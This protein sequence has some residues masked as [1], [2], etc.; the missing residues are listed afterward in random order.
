MEGVTFRRIR[1]R[2]VPIKNSERKELR[3]GGAAIA[4]GAGVSALAGAAYRAINFTAT[5]LASRGTRINESMKIDPSPQLSMF[6][7]ARNEH[8]QAIASKAL[9]NAD[10]IGRFAKPTRLI[11]LAIGSSAIAYGASK[12]ARALRRKDD[13]KNAAI[14]AA[15]GTALFTSGGAALGAF[16]VGMYPKA[17]FKNAMKAVY[18]VAKAKF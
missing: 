8:R 9:K 6:T 3:R 1:G 10:R 15:T 2:I 16:K 11:G 12:V 13:S 17:G 4:A 7:Y 5:D 14:G 18:R